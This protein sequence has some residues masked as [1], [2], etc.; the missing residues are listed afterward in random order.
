MRISDWSSDVCSSD[1][2]AVGRARRQQAG[3]I[4]QVAQIVDEA[5]FQIA[6]PGDAVVAQAALDFA[7]AYVSGISADRAGEET[8]NRFGGGGAAIPK[9]ISARIS[10]PRSLGA[11]IALSL[12]LLS[13]RSISVH[14]MW[15]ATA[16]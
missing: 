8:G 1:L 3:F 4:T 15:P 10:G 16:S 7:V 6:A 5:A 12:V 14:C 11:S 2:R 9:E 13:H